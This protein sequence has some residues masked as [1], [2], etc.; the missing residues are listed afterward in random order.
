VPRLGGDRLVGTV[1]VRRAVARRTVGEL[2]LVTA[3]TLT[4]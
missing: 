2:V 4:R 3:P 1:G